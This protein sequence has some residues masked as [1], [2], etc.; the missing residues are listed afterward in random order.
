MAA[1]YEG[2]PQ[3]QFPRDGRNVRLLSDLVLFDPQETR[4]AVSTG[5]TVDGASI[6]RIFWAKNSR[7]LLKHRDTCPLMGCRLSSTSLPIDSSYNSISESI[8]LNS[9]LRIVLKKKI[10]A[11]PS[12]GE[13]LADSEQSAL[14]T[15]VEAK[16]DDLD[17]ASI[18]QIADSTTSP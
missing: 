3:V 1:R 8:D 17:L 13:R 12:P 16:I 6:P 7:G 10:V 18:E 15:R 11:I 2:T 9:L 4:W 5:A 14:M